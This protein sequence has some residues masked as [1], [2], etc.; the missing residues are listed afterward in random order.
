MPPVEFKKEVLDLRYR[1]WREAENQGWEIFDVVEEYSVSWRAIQWGY[2]FRTSFGTVMSWFP[3]SSRS[4]WYEPGNVFAHS[5]SDRT[6]AAL[7][8]DL[9]TRRFDKEFR[10]DRKDVDR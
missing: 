5:N 1:N 8:V 2:Q 7:L 6:P 10:V 9:C 4:M 3:S